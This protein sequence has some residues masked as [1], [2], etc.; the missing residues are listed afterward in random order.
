MANSLWKQIKYSLVILM[1]SPWGLLYGQDSLQRT[2]IPD[3]SNTGAKKTDSFPA[4]RQKIMYVIGNIFISG[5]RKTKAYIIEREFPYK[6][7]DSVRLSDL[8]NAFVRS[9]ELLI[10]T[11]LFNEVVIS[12]KGFRGYVADIQID[13]KE[14]WYIF[15]IPYVQPVD[16]NFTAWA[17]KNYSLSRLNYGLRFAYYNFTGRNDL[18]RIWLITGYTKQVELAYD[19]PYADKSLK[20]GFGFGLSYAAMN[21]INALT[22]DNQQYFIDSDTIPFAGKF[23][24][25]QLSFSLRYYF[26]PAIRTKHFIRL[27]Y[28]DVKIDS[29]VTVWN[30]HYFNNNLMRIN[31]PELSYVLNY[32]NIDYVPYPLKGFL[33]ETGILQRGI[34]A[35]MHLT[36]A[37]A[38][39]VEAWPIFKKTYF[40]T[41]NM[42]LIKVP[43][44][45]PFYNQQLLGYGDY[46][47]RGLEKYVV[48]GVAGTLVRNTL[49]R[50]LFSFSIPFIRGTAH[51]RIPFRVFAKSYVD[52]G[53]VYNKDFT[54]NSLVN[55]FLYTGGAGLDVVTFYDF[56]FRFE[57]SFN[58]LGESGFFFHIKNDF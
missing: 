11:R 5:N 12:L 16:R 32:N 15:P 24:R 56:V 18:L 27:S 9:R 23:L 29:A 33:F 52:A 47:L 14:R 3:P 42:G 36:Q 57:Y 7:G 43:F 41:Q 55:R 54:S 38:K 50:E 46:Y 31:Y 20:H 25:E 4:N 45:Q 13:V 26:R 8:S 48:D 37:Y 49:I 6:Q 17:E 34:N 44:E 2:F 1:I 22:V 19:Q 10:N 51:D 30:P 39:S 53:Y 21:E 58:Q 40:V 28:N 35:D